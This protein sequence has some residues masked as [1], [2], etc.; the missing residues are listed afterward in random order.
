MY[1]KDTDSQLQGV[2]CVLQKFN[3]DGSLSD[4][5]PGLMVRLMH[6]RYSC[7]ILEIYRKW[8]IGSETKFAFDFASQIL[9]LGFLNVS[10]ARFTYS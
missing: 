9:I 8:Q 10:L 1:L 2:P 5:S 6:A 3:K 7:N 4:E